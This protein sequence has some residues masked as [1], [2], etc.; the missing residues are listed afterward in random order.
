MG[1]IANGWVLSGVTIVQ[2]STPLTFTDARAGTIYGLSGN[3]SG[4]TP[5]P[6]GAVTFGAYNYGRA[7]MASGATYAQIDTTGSVE[8]RLGG[9]SGGPSFFNLSAFAAPPIIGADGKATDFGNSGVGIVRGPGQFNFDFSLVKSTRVGG[10]HENAVLQIR[11]EFFNAFN[12]PQFNN[13]GTSV[14]T[15]P[16]FGVITSTSVNPRLIQFAM[17]YVF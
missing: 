9:S 16:T 17:K 14:S 1:A 15:L 3:N 2:A 6:L 4:T 8:S 7:Q 10:I 12:H 5:P 11:A 13:P